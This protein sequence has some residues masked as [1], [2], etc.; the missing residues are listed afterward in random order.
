MS[1][2][3][4]GEIR[5]F[6]GN[7]AP[8]GWAFCDGQLLSIA[9]NDVL[10][11]LIGTTYGGDGQN[12]FALPDLRARVPVHQGSGAG[13]STRVIGEAGGGQ[14][15]AL[16]V[17][18]MPAHTHEA[19]AA[20]DGVRTPSPVGGLHAIGEADLFLSAAPDALQSPLS[21]VGGSQPH[22]NEQPVR[23]VN[24]IISLV[25]IFPSPS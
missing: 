14:Q 4:I 10:F 22:Q 3:F 6:G 23:C 19:L 18:Q 9:E 2:P 24:F 11:A 21:A 13:L 16:T 15:V 8:V 25:G 20:R 1:N 7:F 12:T 5:M 17:P